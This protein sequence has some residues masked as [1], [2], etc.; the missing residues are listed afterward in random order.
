[1]RCLAPWVAAL[2]IAGC[3]SPPESAAPPRAAAPQPAVQAPRPAMQAPQSAVQGWTSV[4][5]RNPGFEDAPDTRRACPIGWDCTMHAD[6]GA[7]R[8]FHDEAAP[9]QGKRSLCI[10]P[11]KKEP[12]AVAS[13]GLFDMAR[14]RG[15]RVR[16]SVALRLDAV[17]GDGAG[18]F[19]SAQGSGGAVVAH[20][21]R[22]LQGTQGWQRVE[23]EM[24]VPAGAT[25]VEVGVSLE[26]RGRACFD[27]ARLE[28]LRLQKSPV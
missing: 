16:F 20:A 9:A 12:W 4:A 2:F 11:V 10:E 26:G 28:I 13:Q 6:P 5:L 21:G 27:E 3:A 14:F 22:L 23:I 17:T 24:D 15:G 8:F 7:F 19:A 1:M 18:P 25:L